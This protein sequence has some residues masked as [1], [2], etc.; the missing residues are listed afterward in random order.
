MI[1]ANPDWFA[2]VMTPDECLD[3]AFNVAAPIEDSPAE[4]HIGTARTIGAFAV[5]GS[6]TASTQSRIFGSGQKFDVGHARR[7][8]AAR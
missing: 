4:P 8:R 5:Q 3:V 7:L 1:A 6:Q 2:A